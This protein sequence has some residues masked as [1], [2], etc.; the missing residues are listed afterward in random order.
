MHYHHFSVEERERI[1]LGLREERS[2]R[3]IAGDLGRSVSSVSR[4]IRRNLPPE[5]FRYAPRLAH[6]RALRS[7]RRRGEAAEVE[8]KCGQSARSR[9]ES[10][11]TVL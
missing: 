1:Q 3:A 6:E 10:K 11:G 8:K 4:E 2:Y 9:R 5:R 7:R